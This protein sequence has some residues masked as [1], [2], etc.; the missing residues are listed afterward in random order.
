ME[1]LLS[2][3]SGVV[4]AALASLAT[5]EEDKIE[6]FFAGGGNASHILHYLDSAQE[7]VKANDVAAVFNAIE[8]LISHVVRCDIAMVVNM[9]AISKCP[10]VLMLTVPGCRVR[11]CGECCPTTTR[12]WCCS[13][14]GP[15]PRTRPRPSS[16][17]SPASSCSAP[18]RPGQLDTRMM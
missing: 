2:S 4:L 10:G 5:S 1:Q 15:T 11:S 6:E 7:K 17:C 9:M 16:G 13:S 12:R 8:A 3:D 18:A 14:R